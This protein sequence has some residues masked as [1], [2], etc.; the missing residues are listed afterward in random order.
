[1]IYK[2]SIAK[3]I[4]TVANGYRREEFAN[5]LAKEL[6][7]LADMQ[8]SAE[9]RIDLENYLQEWTDLAC[10]YESQYVDLCTVYSLS[11]DCIDDIR[12][13]YAYQIVKNIDAVKRIQRLRQHKGREVFLEVCW[14]SG[15]SQDMAY[16][17]LMRDL[18]DPDY[19]PL[20]DAAISDDGFD[21]LLRKLRSNSGMGNN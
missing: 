10:D 14:R 1:M 4:H 9:K 5:Q 18:Y 11:L 15:L 8:T 17:N 13:S 12:L 7:S 16:E 19:A 20:G 6:L 2:Q 21:A 3:P